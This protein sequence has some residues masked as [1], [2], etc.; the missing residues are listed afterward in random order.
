MEPITA[1]VHQ[2]GTRTC[3]TTSTGKS[4]ALPESWTAALFKKFSL[5]YGNLWNSQFGTQ[6]MTDAAMK[7]WG[8]YLGELKP[9]QIKRGLANLPDFPP[10]LPAFKNLCLV[11]DSLHNSAAYR[12]FGKALP[13]PKADPAIAADALKKI[14]VRPGMTKEQMDA[15]LAKLGRD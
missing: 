10:S 11:A 15:E 14:R 9:E 1:R 4:Q 5:A 2:S 8:Q 6:E 13:K 12:M 7:E 3:T